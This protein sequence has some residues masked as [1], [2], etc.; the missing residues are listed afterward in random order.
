MESEQAESMSKL[1]EGLTLC[2]QNENN[3]MSQTKN[4]NNSTRKEL[5]VTPFYKII[6]N[7]NYG[8]INKNTAIGKKYHIGIKQI[9]NVFPVIYISTSNYL[10]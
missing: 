10:K 4:G 2:D 7:Y 5:S 6:D 8:L 1:T 9:L 3:L